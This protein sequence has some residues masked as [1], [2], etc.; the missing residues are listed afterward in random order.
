MK[1]FI[2]LSMFFVVLCSFIGSFSVMASE[3]IIFDFSIEPK[4]EI[5][6]TDPEQGD[7]W[8][9]YWDDGLSFLGKYNLTRV[10]FSYDKNEKA[11][12]FTAHTQ[13]G[14]MDPY[15]V[16][17]KPGTNTGTDMPEKY[18]VDT[19]KYKYIKVMYKANSDTAS[20]SAFHWISTNVPAYDDGNAYLYS[21][22]AN[23]E[24][25]EITLDMNGVLAWE[26]AGVI[27]QLRIGTYRSGTIS[28]KDTMAYKYIGF[29]KTREE[30]DAY[31]RLDT[32]T[33]VPQP[34]ENTGK[35]KDAKGNDLYILF[36]ILA[37]I[38]V[39]MVGVFFVRSKRDKE[40]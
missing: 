32:R 13:T 3:A 22:T 36:I 9:I 39:V 34:T 1:R 17:A 31:S 27:T 8:N 30:A 12:V 7:N 35:E 5:V 6:A 33:P 18:H 4:Y 11:C 25:Q 20:T 38:V 28:D 26:Y 2:V 37:V 10:S 21:I 24:W 19:S 15:I 29:F 14:V 23:N 40:S 16:A